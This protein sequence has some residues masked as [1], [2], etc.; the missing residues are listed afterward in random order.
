MYLYISLKIQCFFE[1]EKISL[2]GREALTGF[3][4]T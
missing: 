1:K 3:Q 4:Y 2:K